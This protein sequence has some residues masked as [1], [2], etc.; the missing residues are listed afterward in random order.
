MNDM[1]ELM[2]HFLQDIYYAEK[3]GLR[4]AAKL[5]KAVENEELKQAL[6]EHRQQSQH[7]VERLA[8]VFAA[9]GKK[10]K[11]KPCA[12]MEG[13]IEECNEAISEGE[14]GPVLDAALIAC[15]QA[16]EHYE[17]AR[18]GAM[19]AWARQLGLDDAASI[20]AEILDEEKHADERLNEIAE[21][22]VN[23]AAGEEEEDEE[24]EEHEEE[25]HEEEEHEEEAVEEAPPPPKRRSSRAK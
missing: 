20:L 23:A 17:I 22:A 7:Q 6:S 21:Q 1:N 4:S 8:E 16:I 18:Y 3:V 13:L 24:E 2:L 19:E 14:K 15:Q 11:T 10:P 12:A 5:M 9:L 25:E